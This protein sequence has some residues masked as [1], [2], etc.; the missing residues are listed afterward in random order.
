MVV[1]GVEKSIPFKDGTYR[2]TAQ[3]H[4]LEVCVVRAAEGAELPS[5]HGEHAEPN[6]HKIPNY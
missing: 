1:T 6:P 3:A 5:T 4:S 2:S